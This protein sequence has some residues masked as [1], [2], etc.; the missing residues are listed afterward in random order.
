[1][2]TKQLTRSWHGKA[3]MNIKI[4]ISEIM[5]ENSETFVTENR[6]IRIPRNLRNNLGIEIE[7]QFTVK[8]VEGKPII[9]QIAP[10]YLEDVEKDEYVCYVTKKTFDKINLENTEYCEIKIINNIT[11]GCYL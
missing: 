2:S 3:S 4:K 11:L 6:I 9:L 5:T 10:S 1:M 7:E 8:S